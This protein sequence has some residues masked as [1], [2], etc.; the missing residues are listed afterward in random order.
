MKAKWS[1]K[2]KVFKFGGDII[3][4]SKAWRD[5]VITKKKRS[6]ILEGQYWVMQSME[7]HFLLSQDIAISKK[8]ICTST[9]LQA[10]VSTI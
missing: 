1:F 6:S 3:E 8:K 4:W 2:K 7:R 9:F 5:K 10:Q